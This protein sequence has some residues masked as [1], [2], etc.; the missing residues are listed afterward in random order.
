MIHTNDLRK[1][2]VVIIDNQLYVCV[3]QNHH[4]P[5]KGHAMVRAK[6][7]NIKTGSTSDYT[8]RT[9]E[10]L[11]EAVIEK[12]GA[13]YLYHDGDHYI[14]MEQESYEQL[15]IP[16][17]VIGDGK[18]FL[19]ENME[20][21]LDKHDEEVITIQL[22]MFVEFEVIHTEPG[23]KGDTVSGGTKPAEIST[24]YT[25]NVPLFVNIGDVIRVDTRTGTYMERA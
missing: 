19:L 7:R 18:N 12:V 11:E 15:E 5:G 6:L 3:D 21:I 1:G 14:F 25:V 4:K 8:F 2:H 9:D 20:V 16:E 10:K 23:L 17:D 22:P 24:G 13:T